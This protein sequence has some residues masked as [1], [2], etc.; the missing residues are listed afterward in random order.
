MKLVKM[1]VAS[2]IQFPARSDPY[3]H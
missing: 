1:F 3:L 2:H